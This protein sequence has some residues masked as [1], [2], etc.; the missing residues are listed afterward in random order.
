MA[1]NQRD[2][3]ENKSGV[4]QTEVA[5]ETVSQPLDRGCVQDIDAMLDRGVA[6]LRASGRLRYEDDEADRSLVL[7]VVD[8]V[9]PVR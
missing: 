5:P 8:A 4:P 6:A 1:P 9:M 2:R 3:S 7:A